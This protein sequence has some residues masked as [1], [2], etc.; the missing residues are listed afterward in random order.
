MSTAATRTATGPVATWPE[1]RS[2]ATVRA[3]AA[4]PE[5]GE[6]VERRAVAAP[7]LGD[8]RPHVGAEGSV[9]DLRRQRRV[10][11]LLGAASDLAVDAERQRERVLDRVGR[12]QRGPRSG[13]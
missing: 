1:P 13:P 3:V 10:V 9:Q 11:G 2:A 6:R 5:R 4:A 12:L 8:E 7:R